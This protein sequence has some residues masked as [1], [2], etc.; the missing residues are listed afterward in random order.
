LTIG[1]VQEM[2]HT[3]K[4]APYIV[5]N[6][7][8]LYASQCKTPPTGLVVG[9]KINYDATPFG[10]TGRDGK[11]P[12]GLNSWKAVVD[13]Q[14]KPETG[15]TVTDADVL[16]SVSNVV[17]SA[18]AAGTIKTPE[19]LSK[20]FA[21]AFV[22]FTRLGEVAAVAPKGREPGQDDEPRRSDW[23]EPPPFDDSDALRF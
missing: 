15:S 3:S 21:A 20:W 13:A 5:V 14:G 1:I 4:G 2:A 11:R 18:C 9:M 16:R 7:T 17:G 19:E 10:D 12:M 8:R 6:G 22:G 23:D